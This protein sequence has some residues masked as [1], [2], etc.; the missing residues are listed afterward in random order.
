MKRAASVSFGLGRGRRDDDLVGGERFQRMRH[1]S[2][3]TQSGN[4]ADDGSVVFPNSSPDALLPS[5]RWS[6]SSVSAA[7]GSCCWL[8]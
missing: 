1:R 4:S 7:R 6:A 3:R 8:V 2:D 5:S